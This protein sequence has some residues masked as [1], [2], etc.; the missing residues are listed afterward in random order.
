MRSDF[1]EM[2]GSY[3][4]EGDYLLPDVI[5]PENPQVGIW[6]DRRSKYLREHQKALYTAMLLGDTLNV[7]LEEVDRT[8]TKMYDCL[9]TQLAKHGGITEQL[10]VTDQ[11]EWVQ[12]MNNIRNSA[13]ETVYQE[14]I[15]V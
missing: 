14:L 10:K 1:E 6:G 5:V 9:T 15:Y 7:H 2:G 13:M 12:R 8:A 4:Q 11:M 3:H